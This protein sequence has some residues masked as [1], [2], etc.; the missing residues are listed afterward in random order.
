[1]KLNT[2]ARYGIKAMLA[3]AGEY[4]SGEKLSVSQ[5]AEMQNVSSAYLEQLIASL[6]RAGLVNASRGVQG[7]YTLSRPPEKINVGE[8]LKALEGSTDLVNCVG[9]GSDEFECDNLASCSA[10]P[11]FIELQKRIDD[12]LFSTSLKDAAENYFTDTER[13]HK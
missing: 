11:I 1:M 3:L 2:K 13:E 8:I 5:L 4:E 7:G 9:C 10:R 6:K 12:F